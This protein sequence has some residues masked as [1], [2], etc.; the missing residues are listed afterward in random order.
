M[1]AAQHAELVPLLFY[2]KRDVGSKGRALMREYPA[3]GLLA[4]DRLEATPALLDVADFDSVSVFPYDA[5][6]WRSSEET[7]TRHRNFI[8]SRKT[9][10]T[11]HRCLTIDVLHCLYLGVFNRFCRIVAWLLLTSG[12]FGRRGS[13]EEQIQVGIIAMGNMLDHW[14]KRRHAADR[15]EGLT[16]ITK[17]SRGRFGTMQDQFFKAK[18]AET[19][20]FMLFLLDILDTHKDRLPQE[21][22][23]LLSAGRALEELMDVFDNA[24]TRMTNSEIQR[25]WDCYMRFLTLTREFDDFKMPKRHVFLHLLE[26]L[27]DL[28]NPK[29]YAN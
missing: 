7:I 29:R 9:G 24:E 13:L 4:G 22:Q 17:L 11:P 18:G 1:T 16:R 5:V 21:A 19:W 10:I 25:A 27:P 6:F 20:G 26:S 15:E 2:D 14:Y 3:L 23:V 28:G 12:L 8:F